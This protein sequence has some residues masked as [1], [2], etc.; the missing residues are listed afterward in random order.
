MKDKIGRLEL[1]QELHKKANANEMQKALQTVY[2]GLAGRVERGEQER[3]LKEYMKR[4]EYSRER[5]TYVERREMEEW[6]EGRM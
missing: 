6:V 2:E 4:E 3:V 5:R 1:E